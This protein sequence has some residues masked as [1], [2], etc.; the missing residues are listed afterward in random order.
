MADTYNKGYAKGLLYA[1]EVMLDEHESHTAF[2]H[3][4]VLIGTARRVT[5]EYKRVTKPASSTKPVR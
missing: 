2:D 4:G 3:A 5:F 1:L